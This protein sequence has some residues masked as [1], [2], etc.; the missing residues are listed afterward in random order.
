M[1]KVAIGI[2]VSK[3]TLD[4]AVTVDG[5]D[6]IASGKFDNN[7]KGHK[8]LHKWMKKYLRKHGD[9]KARYTMEATGSY[10]EGLHENLC[11]SA[12]T[13]TVENP[14]KNKSFAKMQMMRTKTDA[15]VCPVYLD[16]RAAGYT[17]H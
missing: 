6:I 1:D 5:E 13:V 17:S 7:T 2:E 15:A 8:A 4:V 11:E 10:S 14:M 9:T 16:N 3:K 12:E